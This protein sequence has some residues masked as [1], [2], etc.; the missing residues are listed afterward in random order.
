MSKL[1]NILGPHSLARMEEC[2]L[3]EEVR[4]LVEHWG[5]SLARFYLNTR[6]KK[7]EEETVEQFM[8][9]LEKVSE[10]CGY[11]EKCTQ[12]GVQ[13]DFSA[14]IV[15][16]HMLAVKDPGVYCKY[17]SKY[18]KEEDRKLSEVEDMKEGEVVMEQ[19][20]VKDGEEGI[21]E[22]FDGGMKGT[23]K[24]ESCNDELTGYTCPDC[25]TS[26]RFTTIAGLKRHRQIFCTK[27]KLN[28]EGIRC[29]LCKI[30]F[31]GEIYLKRHM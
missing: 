11:T 18:R 10:Y 4:V 26:Y 20:D 21:K 23:D 29:V 24:V 31:K 12:C 9:R 15:Q 7:E 16:D 27:S 25:F 5:P 22:V 17:S 2:Q 19:M 30:T 14:Q 13:V 1:R 8:S 3:L 6:I 28:G